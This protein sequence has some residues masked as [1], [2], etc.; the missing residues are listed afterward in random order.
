MENIESRAGAL[1]PGLR[2]NLAVGET[3]LLL[4]CLDDV[5]LDALLCDAVLLRATLLCESALFDALL[6]CAVL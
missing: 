4:P 1:S 3:S 2:L 5:L 6:C